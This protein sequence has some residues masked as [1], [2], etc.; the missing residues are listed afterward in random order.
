M[1]SNLVNFSELAQN[2]FQ[3]YLKAKNS[4]EQEAKIKPINVTQ[5]DFED[6]TKVENCTKEEVK[7]KIYELLD[8]LAENEQ[9]LQE[10]VFIKTIKNRN[11]SAYI[12]FYYG[13]HEVIDG[14]YNI[15]NGDGSLELESD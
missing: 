8:Q 11:K 6:S 12:S 14:H 2:N 13:L 1:L 10:E 7:I 5:D 9:E 3:S 15:E 4:D